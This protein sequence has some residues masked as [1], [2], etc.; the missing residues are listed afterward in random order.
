MPQASANGVVPN[1]NAVALVGIGDSPNTSLSY[2]ARIREVR[3]NDRIPNRVK[4]LLNLRANEIGIITIPEAA[5]NQYFGPPMDP[6]I[7]NFPILRNIIAK[8]S[9]ASNLEGILKQEGSVKVQVSDQSISEYS[10]KDFQLKI[11]V[12]DQKAVGQNADIYALRIWITTNGLT[13][14]YELSVY[15]GHSLVYRLPPP[16]DLGLVILVG[17]DPSPATANSK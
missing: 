11:E 3:G 15:S 7:S 8:K 6:S 10:G 2:S 12:V 4:S 17:N 1:A 13:M 16:A 9:L 5:L 14:P